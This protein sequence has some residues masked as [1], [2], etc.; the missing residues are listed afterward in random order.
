VYQSIESLRNQH[1][2]RME[3]IEHKSKHLASAKQL[4]SLKTKVLNNEAKLVLLDNNLSEV[5]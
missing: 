5:Q 4:D 3:D 2:L 1:V